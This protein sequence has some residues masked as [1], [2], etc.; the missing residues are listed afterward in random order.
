MFFDFR[1]DGHIFAGEDRSDPFR[2]P[3]ALGD[4]VDPR[5][6]L[7]GDRVDRILG[8][9]AAKIVPVAAHRERRGAGR[10][11]EIEDEDLRFSIAAKLQRH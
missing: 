9:R 11:A 8:E 10:A 1:R 4:L 6:G 3:G 2:R 5:Q 7:Q